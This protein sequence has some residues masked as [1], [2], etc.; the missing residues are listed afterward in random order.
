MP[1][2]EYSWPKVAVANVK[3]TERSLRFGRDD[4]FGVRAR[5]KDGRGR[6][7]PL[8]SRR[9]GAAGGAALMAKA[10]CARR[11]RGTMRRLDVHIGNS[12]YRVIKT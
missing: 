5:A 3:A 7:P 11:E 12:G 2:F 9:Q 1:V 8:Q 10:L 4:R 6:A